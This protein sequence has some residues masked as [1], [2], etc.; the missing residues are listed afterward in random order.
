MFLRRT[1]SNGWIKS[2]DRLV[3]FSAIAKQFH[4][5]WPQSSYLAGLWRHQL[6]QAL[7]WEPVRSR[8]R[9]RP[10]KYRGPSWSWAAMDGEV[11][12]FCGNSKGC[13]C[14]IAELQVDLKNPEHPFGEV[15][16]GLLVLS[17]IIQ[18]A[19][20]DADKMELFEKD[21]SNRALVLSSNE[22]SQNGEIGYAIADAVEVSS[23][24]CDIF[25]AVIRDTGRLGPR[26]LG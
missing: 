23:A 19:A 24:V 13:L 17:A 26:Y 20:W 1:R 4:E 18:I 22:D 16:G 3:A 7:L 8:Q 6:P 2:K 5:L 15:T 10:S 25:V 21:S 9:P 14:T 11:K 12:A